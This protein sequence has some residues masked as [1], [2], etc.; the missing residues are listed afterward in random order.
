[1]VEEITRALRE[2]LLP[3]FGVLGA[4]AEKV[5]HRQE[6]GVRECDQEVG[7]DEDVQLGGVQPL[8]ALVIEGKVE[9]DE[10]IALVLVHL[11]TLPLGEHVFDVE[12]VEAKTVGKQGRLERSRLVDVDPGEAVSGELGDARLDP[13]G[14]IPGGS[15]GPSTPDAGECRPCHRY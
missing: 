8:D 1:V 12:L 9:N 7:A 11:G 10:E 15:P 4:A 6:L 5:R 13:L 3:Q 14:E 2:E